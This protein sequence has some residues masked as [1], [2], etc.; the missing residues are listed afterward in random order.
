M[1]IDYNAQ[2]VF[3]ISLTQEQAQKITALIGDPEDYLFLWMGETLP[4]QEYADLFFRCSSPYYCADEYRYFLSIIDPVKTEIS[5]EELTSTLANWR[6][7]SF[8]RF[9]AFA[10]IEPTKPRLYSLCNVC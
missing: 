7:T 2:L 3:G 6:N 4:P 1:G 9:L 8:L 10:G 5:I